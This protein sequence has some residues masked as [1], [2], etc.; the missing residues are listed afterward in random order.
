MVRNRLSGSGR[1]FVKVF[2]SYQ[3]PVAGEAIERIAKLYDVEKRARFKSPV[4]RVA[5][6]QEYAKPIFDDLEAWLRKQLGRLSGKTPLAKAI[7]YPAVA[8]CSDERGICA[9]P[10]AQGA[11]LSGSRVSG[12]G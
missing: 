1:E 6:R 5:L 2:E 7:Y 11:A 10:P 3:L 8:A 4:D 9:D 12:V